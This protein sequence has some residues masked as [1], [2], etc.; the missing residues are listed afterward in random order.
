VFAD[1]GQRAT[2][3]PILEIVNSEGK[4]LVDNIHPLPKTSTALPA[5]VAD[6]VTNVLQGVIQYGTGTKANIGRPAAGKTG[7][8][9][10]N[11]DAWFVGYTPTLSTAVWMGD[12][13]SDSVPVGAGPGCPHG[14]VTGHYVGGGSATFYGLYGGQW[15]AIAWGEY[16]KEA[17]KNVP[18]TPFSAPAPI[19]T[20]QEAAALQA[21][22]TTT[23]LP[24]RPGY[25]GVI[26]SVPPGGPYSIPPPQVYAPPPTTTPETTTTNPFSTTSTSNPPGGFNSG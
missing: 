5:N 10:N 22:Q 18:V 23:T 6:N 16:M 12:P 19:I 3:T 11:T 21:R 24:I 13:H 4:V 7:T 15:P 2:P 1:H 8:T 17:L 26:T 14:C 9:S 25:G 20:P